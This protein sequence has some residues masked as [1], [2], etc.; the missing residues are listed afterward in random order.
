MPAPMTVKNIPIT[1]MIAAQPMSW[2]VEIAR[3]EIMVR[4]SWLSTRKAFSRP[5]GISLYWLHLKGLDA[6]ACPPIDSLRRN[7]DH[8]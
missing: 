2:I 3:S 6:S 8:G 5:C 7:M 1:I 4:I